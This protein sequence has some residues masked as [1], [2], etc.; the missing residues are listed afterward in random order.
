MEEMLISLLKWTDDVVVIPARI[1]GLVVGFFVLRWVI[2]RVINRL[3]RRTI[4][5][6]VPGVLAKSPRA[7]AFVENNLASHERRRQRAETVASL[8]KSVT[9]I[10]LSTVLLVMVLDELGF[11]ILP[12]IASA[13]IVGVALGFGA[14]TLV[15]DFLAGIFMILEDQFGVGDYIDMEKASGVVEAVGLRITRLRG[16]DGT[17]WYVRNGEVMRVGNQAERD[18][19]AALGTPAVLGDP[20]SAEPAGPAEVGVPVEQT[21]AADLGT[22]PVDPPTR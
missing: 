21:S 20:T 6:S 15:K 9:T 3:A 10:V 19:P 8:L 18:S 22:A 5:G 17:I 2:H 1:A 4:A 13:S 16:D 14:Q 11:K 12:V 7:S